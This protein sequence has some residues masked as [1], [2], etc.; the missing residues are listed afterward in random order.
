MDIISYNTFKKRYN[1]TIYCVRDGVKGW[2][3]QTVT[4]TLR[5]HGWKSC[6]QEYDYGLSSAHNREREKP[7]DMAKRLLLKEWG[8]QW[9]KDKK[10]VYYLYEGN[11]GY[12]DVLYVYYKE[13]DEQ[14][15]ID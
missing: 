1:P 11:N 9:C 6:I 10:F 12:M 8:E 7:K 5:H 13:K 15:I 4:P 3:V 14:E 2:A